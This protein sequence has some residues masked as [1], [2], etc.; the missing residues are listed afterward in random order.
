MAQFTYVHEDDVGGIETETRQYPC[1]KAPKRIKVG[2]RWFTK[3]FVADLMT[4]TT[5]P[6]SGT[7]VGGDGKK[8]YP[9]YSKAMGVH[10]SQI[11]EFQE[12]YKRAGLGEQEFDRLGNPKVTDGKHREKL[13]KARNFV[14]N[15]SFTGY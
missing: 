7:G 13:M 9:Y 4:G 8:A 15:N 6:K 10:P 11:P 2:G 1:G 5:A 3:S 12:V 14:D